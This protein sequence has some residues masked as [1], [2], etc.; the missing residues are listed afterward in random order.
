M[1]DQT[2]WENE[3]SEQN[4]AQ[5]IAEIEKAF[6]TFYTPYAHELAW[7]VARCRTLE[8]VAYAVQRTQS[9]D[10]NERIVGGRDLQ[11]AM[12]EVGLGD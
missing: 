7:L 11:A 4:P 1:S 5:R 3:L 12:R 10:I 8:K 2:P 6:E 9:A